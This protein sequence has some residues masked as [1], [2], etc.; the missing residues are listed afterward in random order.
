VPVRRPL[1]GRGINSFIID[2]KVFLRSLKIVATVTAGHSDYANHMVVNL[3]TVR[4]SGSVQITS[5]WAN[6]H[7]DI[8]ALEAKDTTN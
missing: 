8:I 6:G 5:P 2:R 4:A 7:Y 1:A 3:A